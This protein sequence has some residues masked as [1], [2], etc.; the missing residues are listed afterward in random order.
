MILGLL[1]VLACLWS[2]P[3]AAEPDAVTA[4]RLEALVRAAAEARIAASGREQRIRV[5]GLARQLELR[6]CETTPAV[7]LPE[8]LDFGRH[9]AEVSCSGPVAWRVRVPFELREWAEVVIAARALP[10]GVAITAADVDIDR[11][12]LSVRTEDA[13]RRRADVVGNFTARPIAAG[14]VIEAS[15]LDRP[16]L[17]GRG[18][19][20]TLRAVA[21]GI[22]IVT[23]G[24]ALRDG[25]LGERIPV[26]NV[27]SGR[28]L[29]G[30][31][32]ASGVVRIDG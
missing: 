20:I 28:R 27:R 14:A 13:I 19:L 22:E 15:Q 17:V 9:S 1:V 25:R 12:E 24:K 7:E 3:L 4:A 18:D 21:G 30:T 29:T 16:T 26:E 11:R 32:V 8:R 23:E 2:T 10:R 5:D 6:G 31:V